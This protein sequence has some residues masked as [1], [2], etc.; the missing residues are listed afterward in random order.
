MAEEEETRARVHEFVEYANALMGEAS[1]V[2]STMGTEL[3]VDQGG[4]YFLVRGNYTCPSFPRG[5]VVVRVERATGHIFS[6]S[7]TRVRWSVYA[8]LPGERGFFEGWAEC[9]HSRGVC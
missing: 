7:G 3:H 1:Y 2:P 4:R 5:Y 8:R 6:P 9:L